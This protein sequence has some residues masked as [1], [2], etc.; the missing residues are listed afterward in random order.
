MM[1]FTKTTP[2][3][4][5]E[6]SDWVCEVTKGV[7]YRPYKGKEPGWWTRLMHRVWLDFRWSRVPK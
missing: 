7:F 5:H 4:I 2:P 3:L 6:Y 1:L